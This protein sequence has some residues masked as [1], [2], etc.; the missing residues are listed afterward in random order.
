MIINRQVKEKQLSRHPS[1]VNILLLHF[2]IRSKNLIQETQ[3]Y[4]RTRSSSS[5]VNSMAFWWTVFVL[6]FVYAICRFL[7]M[8]IPPNVPSIEV[9][10][11]DGDKFTLSFSLYI[12]MVLNSFALERFMPPFFYFVFDH[13]FRLILLQLWTTGIR[14]RRIATSM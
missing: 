11:S 13:L 8:L 12:L 7:V 4:R 2:T 3:V 9:D 14:R 1:S 6:G 5:S 10:A